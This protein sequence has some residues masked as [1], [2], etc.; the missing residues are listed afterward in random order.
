MFLRLSGVPWDEFRV[1]W[2]LYQAENRHRITQLLV[3]ALAVTIL[4]I[5]LAPYMSLS[6]ELGVLLHQLGLWEHWHNFENPAIDIQGILPLFIPLSYHLV[7]RMEEIPLPFGN[8]HI[9]VCRF[10]M[11]IFIVCTLSMYCGMAIYTF[12]HDYNSGWTIADVIYRFLLPIAS[13]PLSAAMAFP[14]IVI[15]SLLSSELKPT[16][17]WK[18]T[19]S[20]WALAFL[21]SG[22]IFWWM[23]TDISGDTFFNAFSPV[24]VFTAL[25]PILLIIALWRYRMRLLVTYSVLTMINIP[26]YYI[27]TGQAQYQYAVLKCYVNFYA[28]IGLLENMHFVYVDMIQ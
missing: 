19:Y 24:M 21:L 26:L 10:M 17:R 4:T 20:I 14:Q 18:A 1:A 15:A 8:R 16:H 22:S 3:I 2:R 23:P 7:P 27:L 25:L 28:A 12:R 6:R 11:L 5:F 9:Q 13:I